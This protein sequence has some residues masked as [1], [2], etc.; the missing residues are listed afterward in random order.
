MPTFFMQV[1]VTQLN[2]PSKIDNS[3]K[4]LSICWKRGN[5]GVYKFIFQCQWKESFMAMHISLLILYHLFIYATDHSYCNTN[6]IYGE[7]LVEAF[8]RSVVIFCF[9]YRSPGSHEFTLQQYLNRQ[10]HILHGYEARKLKHVPK[11]SL[12]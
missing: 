1:L 9:F 7:H 2:F 8:L 12:T 6:Q 5:C 11:A 10:K 4:Q 3:V